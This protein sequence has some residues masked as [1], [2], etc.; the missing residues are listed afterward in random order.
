MKNLEQRVKL[1]C[2]LEEVCLESQVTGE[3]LPSDE[4]IAQFY[5]DHDTTEDWHSE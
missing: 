4:A 3:L 1:P 2:P 5:K